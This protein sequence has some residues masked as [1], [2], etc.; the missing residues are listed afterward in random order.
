MGSIC[1]KSD[2]NTYLTKQV[3]SPVKIHPAPPETPANPSTNQV[4]LSVC[5]RQNRLSIQI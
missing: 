2:S 3:Q 1:Q 5:P 4:S